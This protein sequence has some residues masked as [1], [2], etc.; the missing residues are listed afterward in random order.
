[1]FDIFDMLKKDKDEKK[2]AVKQVTRET[3]IGDILDMDQTTA[4]YFM[5]IGMHCLG[6]PASRGESIADMALRHGVCFS[7]GYNARVPGWMQCHYRLQF[8]E[9]G[10]PRF[11]V[12]E[13]CANFLRTIPLLRFSEQNPEDLDTEGEDHIADEWRYLCM[14]RPVRP[15]CAPPERDWTRNPLQK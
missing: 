11:Y 4:P 12:F 5:E 6:C 3:I 15:L 14:S 9:N 7:P 1:M 2:A 10:F 8:D 13:T